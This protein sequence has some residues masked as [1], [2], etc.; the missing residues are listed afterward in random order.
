MTEALWVHQWHNVVD[1]DLLKRDAALAR[2]ARP[3]RRRRACSA[4]GA[5]ACPMRWRC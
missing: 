1:V 4:T 3:R 5:T 2:A